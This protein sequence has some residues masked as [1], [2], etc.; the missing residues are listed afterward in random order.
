MPQPPDRQPTIHDVAA[1]AGVS[2][3]TVSRVLNAESNVRAETRERVNAAVRRLDYYPNPA[4]RRLAGRRSYL[5]A[6]AYDNPS[7]NYLSYVIDG[8]LDVCRSDG[9]FLALHGCSFEDAALARHMIN[10]VRE[11]RVDGLVLA[12]PVSDVKGL[13]PAL[14]DAGVRYARL[15]P[16]GEGKGPGVAI[17]DRQAA[18]DMTE[19][20]LGLG[21]RRIGFVRG[22]P[23]HGASRWREEGYRQALARHRLDV[24]PALIHQGS[25]TLESGV[26]AARHFLKSAEPPTAIFASNDDMAAGI[27]QEAVRRG[28]SVPD[29]LSVAGYDDTPIARMLTPRLTTISQPV[30][31]MGRRAAEMLFEI[32]AEPRLPDDRPPLVETL[33][34]RLVL[35]QSTA[36]P[37]PR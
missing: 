23:L 8:I 2:I 4:A 30:R 18:F 25:F 16:T 13:C 24:D 36:A 28:I 21:H 34:Y 3:K 1:L 14:D 9:Y 20:L 27:V 31:A 37:R 26:E 5:I 17:D 12:P 11:S 29:D 33:E 32:L 35:R 10:S 15:A 22:H 6:L 7:S 19:Y